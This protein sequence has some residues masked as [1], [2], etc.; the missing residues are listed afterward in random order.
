MKMVPLYIHLN[1]TSDW[2]AI[3]DSNE[4]NFGMTDDVFLGY[5]WSGD[6]GIKNDDNYPISYQVRQWKDR[7]NDHYLITG[8]AMDWHNDCPWGDLWPATDSQ[9]VFVNAY[10]WAGGR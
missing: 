4:T 2:P 8:T 1:H 7:D 10:G 9:P 3:T 6:P 5:M